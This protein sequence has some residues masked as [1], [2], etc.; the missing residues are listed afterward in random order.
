MFFLL[1]VFVWF[2]VVN[3]LLSCFYSLCSSSNVQLCNCLV[4]LLVL[5]YLMLQDR[6]MK[7]CQSCDVEL[8]LSVIS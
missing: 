7:C 3:L 8:T 4:I 2:C 5:T 1:V 6:S